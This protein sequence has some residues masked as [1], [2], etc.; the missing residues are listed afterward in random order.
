MCSAR[1]IRFP[2]APERK[3][4]PCDAGKDKLF[5]LRDFLGFERNVI[6]QATCHGADNSRPGRRLAHAGDVPA[7][8]PRP[9]IVKRRELQKCMPPAC[10][11][12]VSISSSAWPTPSPDAYYRA[13]SSG[14]AA[15]WHVVVYFE[16]ADLAERWDLFTTVTVPS[17]SITWAGPT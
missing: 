4:T 15:G 12:C 11:G 13:L 8:S 16:A 17:W 9:A 2:Y 6:V 10:A 1:A 3:Y 7:A 14:C 5:A